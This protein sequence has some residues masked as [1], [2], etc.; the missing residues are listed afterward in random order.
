MSDDGEIEFLEEDEELDGDYEEQT[1]GGSYPAVEYDEDNTGSA[2]HQYGMSGRRPASSS[3]HLSNQPK[4]SSSSSPSSSAAR[5][6][7]SRETLRVSSKR[8]ILPNI[9]S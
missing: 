4:T 7:Q 8:S 3:K 1:Y 9:I 5:F 2:E 6:Q